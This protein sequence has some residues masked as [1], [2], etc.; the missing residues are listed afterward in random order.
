MGMGDSPADDRSLAAD[1]TPLGHDFLSIAQEHKV[2]FATKI[3][4][5]PFVFI[6]SFVALSL[7]SY[8]TELQILVDG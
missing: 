6:V 3:T 7:C 4:S 5:K 1:L 2:V 8:Q